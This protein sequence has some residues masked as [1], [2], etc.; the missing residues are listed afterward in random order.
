LFGATK[1][2]RLPLGIGRWLQTVLKRTYFTWLQTA[3]YG[4][5]PPVAKDQTHAKSPGSYG[6]KGQLKELQQDKR[7]G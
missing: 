2:Q 1:R 3:A 6:Q 4:L 7:K 5:L